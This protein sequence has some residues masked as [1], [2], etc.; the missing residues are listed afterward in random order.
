MSLGRFVQPA[1]WGHGRR[2]PVPSERMFPDKWAPR[3][4][5]L[6]VITREATDEEQN[7]CRLVF[8]GHDHGIFRT[9][10]LACRAAE[11]QAGERLRWDWVD[12]DRCEA[13]SH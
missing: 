2:P 11:A 6:G 7:R 4:D 9:V 5:L 3:R 13:W 1:G 8:Y 10:D 12:A